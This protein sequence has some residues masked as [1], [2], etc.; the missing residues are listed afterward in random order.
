MLTHLASL[1]K[2]WCSSFLTGFYKRCV[3]R[4]PLRLT[5]PYFLTHPPEKTDTFFCPQTPWFYLLTD[6]TTRSLPHFLCLVNRLSFSTVFQHLSGMFQ[7]SF[8]TSIYAWQTCCHG[9]S[10]R[11]IE[12]SAFVAKPKQTQVTIN[13]NPSNVPVLLSQQL[14]RLFFHLFRELQC[15]LSAP[16]LLAV[17]ALFR[18]LQSSIK[19]NCMLRKVLLKELSI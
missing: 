18:S 13:R 19:D 12:I 7:S 9:V 15:L 10:R 6:R 1:F 3:Q 17:G 11:R 4:A 2:Q 8:P 16:T 5:H 14:L